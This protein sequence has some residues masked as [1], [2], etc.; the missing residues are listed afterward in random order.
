[1][2][3]RVLGMQALEFREGLGSFFLRYPSHTASRPPRWKSS[4]NSMNRPLSLLHLI[5]WRPDSEKS[6]ASPSAVIQHLGK[7]NPTYNQVMSERP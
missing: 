6:E 3:N 1:M 2:Y 4:Y 5:S 7:N